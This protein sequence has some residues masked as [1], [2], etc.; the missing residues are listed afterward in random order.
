MEPTLTTM[1]REQRLQKLFDD[2]QQQVLSQVIGTF[3]LS[4]AMFKDVDRN[5]GN[6]TTLH[7]FAREDDDYVATDSDKKLHEHSRKKYDKQVRAEYEI[8]TQEKA[9]TAGGKT[10]NDKRDERIA[11]GRDEYTGQTVR[12]DG[13]VE[14]KNGEEARAELDHVVSISETHSDPKMHLALGQVSEDGETV[15]VS[16]IREVVNSDENLALTNQPLNGSKADEDLREWAAKERENGET[17]AQKFGADEEL[18]QEKHDTARKHIDSTANRALL[19]KQAT[20][21]LATGGKQAAL[22]G[23]RQALGMLLTELVNALFNEVKAL[24]RHGVELGES[25]L[26][27]IGQRLMHVAEQVARKVPAALSQMIQGGVSGFVSNLLTFL[28][29]NFLSTA[30]RFVSM[31][32]EGLLGLFRAA[33]MMLFPP[34]HMTQAQALQEG[35]K[36]LGTVVIS[37]VG[38]LLSETVATFMA[39]IPFLKPFADLLTPVLVGIASGLLSA[40]LAYQIDCLFDRHARGERLLDELI[41]DAARREA[42][43]AELVTLSEASLGNVERYTQS[44]ELYRQTGAILGNAGLAS[45][46]ALASLD[47]AVAS[48]RE[49]VEKSRRMIDYIDESQAEIDEFLK[50]L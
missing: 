1:T 11:Q 49:Q 45:A 25:L 27:K 28:L 39:T 21:L 37:S 13:T 9:D 4:T 18:I 7:N 22:M 23:A 33:R 34:A 38:I 35:L 31:I 43:A 44:I 26:K 29:N 14:L 20:E 17:N 30:K 2:C 50:T 40:F 5:G 32:R 47:S 3:G 19:K 8:K 6:V 42:F 15:D 48:T 10:W 36:L 16:R 24:I 46:A 12:A 41:A